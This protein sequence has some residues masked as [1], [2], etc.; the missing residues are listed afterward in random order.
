MTTAPWK[1]RYEKFSSP[2]LGRF[3]GRIFFRLLITLF[4]ASIADFAV[5]NI[6][7]GSPAQVIL[8]TQ[9][10]PQKVATLNAKL[11]LGA[12]LYDQYLRWLSQLLTMRLGRSYVSGGRIGTE[13]AQALQITVPLVLGGLGIGIILSIP[14]AFLIYLFRQSRASIF[15]TLV[16]D[17]GISTPSFILG[18]ILIYTFAIKYSVL[19]ASGFIF[20]STSVVGAIR[21]LILPSVAL[22]LVEAAIISRYAKNLIDDVMDTPY[23]HAARLRGQSETQAFLR[24]GLRNIT[25]PLITVV[26]LE[27]SGLLVGAVVV[28][29]VFGLPG[30]GT[31]LL[32]AVQNRDV[33]VVQDIVMLAVT[34]VCTINLLVDL[35]YKRIQPDLRD[36]VL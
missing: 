25:A 30:V 32:N 34:I 22:G 12:P 29:N 1:Q 31:L 3:N 7:P 35:S 14:L 11:G 36:D 4:V 9:A 23:I 17:L 5:I 6:L 24:H 15:V 10:T 27:A 19:P 16:L 20:W 21:S 13:I 26:G 18:L 33:I 8:G 28:E 2:Y